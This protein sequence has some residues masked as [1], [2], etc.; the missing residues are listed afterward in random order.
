M[1]KKKWNKAEKDFSKAVKFEPTVPEHHIWLGNARYQ[2]GD[3]DGAK[4]DYQKALSLDPDLDTSDKS[5]FWY[6]KKRQT[7]VSAAVRGGTF[8]N[9][10]FV[11][12]RK[13][14]A[15]KFEVDETKITIETTGQDL[16]ADSLDT[17]ELIYAIEERMEIAIPDEEAN[18]FETVRDIYE[19]VKSRQ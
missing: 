6:Q 9:E 11:E 12:L 14:I 2:D 15:E 5:L 17:Y 1:M 16:G 13:I 4:A 8:D 7:A 10:L 19:Y 3:T 18:N